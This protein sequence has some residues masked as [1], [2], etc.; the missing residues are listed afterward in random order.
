LITTW[1]RLIRTFREFDNFY[2]ALVHGFRDAAEYWEK[3]NAKQYLHRITVPSLILNARDDP[4]LAPES[5]P[6]AAAEKNTCLFFEAPA[7]GGHVGFIDSVCP[8]RP[9][10]ESRSAEF[11]ATIS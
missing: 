5:F 6:Y 11:L 7:W 3:S 4:F 8:M 1:S 9:W 10:H 2:T